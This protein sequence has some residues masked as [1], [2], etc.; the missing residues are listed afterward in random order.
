ML[1]PRVAARLAREAR[2]ASICGS[3][4]CSRTR[5]C[6]GPSLSTGAVDLAIAPLRPE[7]ERPGIYGKKIFDERF[8]CVVR[9]GH[10]LAAKKLTLARFAAASHA[11]ISPRGKEGGF[12]DDALARLGMKRRVA[13]A[14]PHF[15][16]APHLVASSDLLLTVARRIAEVLAEPL[17]LAVLAPPPE[18]ALDGFTMSLVWHE[19]THGDP[20]ARWLR[21]VLVAEAA[22]IS[23]PRAAPEAGLVP[24]MSENRERATRPG[25]IERGTSLMELLDP[26]LCHEA[27]RTRDERF[28]GRFFVGVTSTGIYCRP[29]CPARTAKR[30]H[31]RFFATAA[32]AQEAGFRPCLQAAGRRRLR[33]GLRGAGRRPPCRAASR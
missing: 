27:L 2:R 12:V 6:R 1:L 23:K 29:I 13:V 26:R 18:L 31:R 15:L 24:S 8:V 19:R 17:G 10:P 32:A 16:V 11:L 33:Q 21:E 25:R 3:C 7:D 28:D 4:T 22:A 30:E 14:V 20:M 5:T 9:K